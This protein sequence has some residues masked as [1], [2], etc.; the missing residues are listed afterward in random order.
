MSDSS[1]KRKVQT[2]KAQPSNKKSKADSDDN[3]PPP[4]NP[5]K[6]K[7]VK[8]KEGAKE[9]T[10]SVKVSHQHRYHWEDQSKRREKSFD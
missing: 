10:K 4:P 7:P 5:P 1:Q 6:K 3:S 2:K 8:K 9:G